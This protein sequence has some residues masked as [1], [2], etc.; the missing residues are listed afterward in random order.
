MSLLLTA[1]AA[2][3][4]MD[5]IFNPSALAMSFL[6]ADGLC[7]CWML[8]VMARIPISTVNYRGIL[9]LQFQRMIPFRSR[10]FVQILA[11][12]IPWLL[13]NLYMPIMM[14]IS[15]LYA[16]GTANAVEGGEAGDW[17]L[18]QLWCFWRTHQLARSLLQGAA[19]PLGFFSG[20]NYSIKRFARVGEFM[21][22]TLVLV[23]ILGLVFA[24]IAFLTAQQLSW[25]IFNPEDTAHTRNLFRELRIPAALGALTAM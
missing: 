11:F 5:F 21:I 6:I 1:S 17:R 16:S 14:I 22:K 3:Q 18:L 8:V 13:Q 25:I 2:A 20:F 15:S 4:R 23:I 19:D 9:T 10:I 7:A 12:S 24:L